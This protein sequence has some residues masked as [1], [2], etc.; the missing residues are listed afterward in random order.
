MSNKPLW[1]LAAISL[2]ASTAA[3][4]PLRYR[5]Q[6]ERDRAWVIDAKGL[7]LEEG[8]KARR[9]I[10]LVDWQWAAEPY[11]CAPDI[12]IGPRGEAIV[13][14]NVLPLL[15]KIDPDTLAVSMHRL[16]LDT[17]ADKDVGFSGLAY[18]A[19]EGAYF[20]VSELHGSLWRIDPM[21]RRAQKIAA[22]APVRGACAVSFQRQE[23]LARFSRF[24][25]HGKTESWLVN[26]APDQRSAYVQT[27][28]C[29][30][31]FAQNGA[32]D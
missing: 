2:F 6:P 3:A 30:A 1:F 15:W 5:S 19:R 18:S 32:F 22:G 7:F 4:D 28:G 13:T 12:A 29:S 23:R 21:L 25:L 27:A 24:C 31:A 11:A 17:D 14:S 9:G 10:G 16:E 26:L 20:A 8:R